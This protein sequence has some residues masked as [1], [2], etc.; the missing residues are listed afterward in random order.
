MS[1]QGHCGRVTANGPAAGFTSGGL[2]VKRLLSCLGSV[3]DHA[4]TE[5]PFADAVSHTTPPR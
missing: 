2:T 3:T 4:L 5:P 1:S